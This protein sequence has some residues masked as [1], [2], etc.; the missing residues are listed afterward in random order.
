ML[1]V[2]SNGPCSL[3]GWWI[4]PAK[5]A[6]QVSLVCASSVLY[7]PASHVV[8]GTDDKEVFLKTELY[9]Y[10]GIN[11]VTF[12]T[13][14]LTPFLGAFNKKRPGLPELGAACEGVSLPSA[15]AIPIAIGWTTM[16][17][18]ERHEEG[19]KRMAGVGTGV[20]VLLGALARF[21]SSKAPGSTSPRGICAG[22][23]GR[24]SDWGA[25]G[26]RSRW[27]ALVARSAGRAIR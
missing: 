15:C 5:A 20:R 21:R 24:Y 11:K 16:P 4:W 23:S 10:L 2:S 12:V 9:A 13:A 6:K 1:A 27:C 8:Q 14:V 22:E 7:L 25:G 17:F 18:A 19:E 3:S 26:A